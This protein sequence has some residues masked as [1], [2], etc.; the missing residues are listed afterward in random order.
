MANRISLKSVHLKK[1]DYRKYDDA[2]SSGAYNIG[3]VPDDID[4][5]PYDTIMRLGNQKKMFTRKTAL[6]DPRNAAR[7]AEKKGYKLNLGQDWDK[8]GV[9]DV[10]VTAGNQ[11]NAF[12]GLMV[13]END[14]KGKQR[15]YDQHKD[16]RKKQ[17][18]RD[19]IRDDV[20]AAAV[21]P[22]QA[23]GYLHRQGADWVNQEYNGFAKPKLRKLSGYDIFRSVFKTLYD[24]F[25]EFLKQ[26]GQDFVHAN[27]TEVSRLLY[28]RIVVDLV[29]PKLG[30]Q[31][32]RQNPALIR[33]LNAIKSKKVIK[34][35]FLSNARNVVKLNGG[36]NVTVI[37]YN[38]LCN[39]HGIQVPEYSNE[40]STGA[41][42]NLKETYEAAHG[43]TVTDEDID[44]F[45]AEKQ[46]E[47]Q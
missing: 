38:A 7:Y 19:F 10:V 1:D 16:M 4:Y 5:G 41:F 39:Y 40:A 8:D 30:S 37:V 31:L 12:N 45:I 42:Q 34:D 18:Y 47:E 28:N 20:Y 26:S 22:N 33:F 25:Y 11:I 3:A 24:N 46:S 36:Q 2:V 17:T 13:G 14:W 23:D 29:N 27:Y 21:D 6:M 32:K 43:S 35:V 15:Y 9:N 44:Q